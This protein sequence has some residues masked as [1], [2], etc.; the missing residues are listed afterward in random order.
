MQNQCNRLSVRIEIK[1]N[2]WGELL[3]SGILFLRLVPMLV[4]CY[5]FYRDKSFLISSIPAPCCC[6]GR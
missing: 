6:Q 5:C 3:I 4:R 2:D 1:G